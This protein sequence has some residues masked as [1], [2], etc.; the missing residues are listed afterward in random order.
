MTRHAWLVVTPKQTTPA[1]SWP[2]L[3][4]LSG[5]RDAGSL[6]LCQH[7]REI[8]AVASRC[9][10]LPA[11]VRKFAAPWTSAP[12]YGFLQSSQ[13]PGIRINPVDYRELLQQLIMPLP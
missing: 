8:K 13:R 6:Y 3:F 11:G 2:Q 5:Q 9:S 1:W 7:V 4:V 12:G 10:E